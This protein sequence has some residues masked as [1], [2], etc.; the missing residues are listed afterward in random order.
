MIPVIFQVFSRLNR[1]PR[2]S[3]HHAEAGL[4][5]KTADS[6]DLRFTHGYLLITYYLW[7]RVMVSQIDRAGIGGVVGAC[8]F[9]VEVEVYRE[10]APRVD[11]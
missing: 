1:C 6:V 2:P 11:A 9:I 10:V 8:G 7:N 3:R 4:L 5:G